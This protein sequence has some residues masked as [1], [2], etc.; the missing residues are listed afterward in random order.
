MPSNIESFEGF[1]LKLK[2][3][4]LS[5][6]GAPKASD[7]NSELRSGDK[8]L[9][10]LKG[11]SDV[12]VAI[13]A[14]NDPAVV[15]P[16]PP[17]VPSTTQQSNPAAKASLVSKKDARIDAVSVAPRSSAEKIAKPAPWDLPDPPPREP[18]KTFSEVMSAF[19]QEKKHA[20]G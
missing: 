16:E 6:R 15:A 14:G 4:G 11:V 1:S 3:R 10:A 5:R 19:M 7:A 13:V 9:G 20:L 2:V 12:P 18:R 8:S 17:V